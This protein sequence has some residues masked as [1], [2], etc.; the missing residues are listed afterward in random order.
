MLQ[1]LNLTGTGHTFT[2]RS[3]TPVSLYGTQQNNIN[4]N[5]ILIDFAADFH[6]LLK[7]LKKIIMLLN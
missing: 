6:S 4:S 1:I 5:K 3:W 7:I 2:Q